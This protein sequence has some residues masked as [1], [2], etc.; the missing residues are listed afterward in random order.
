MWSIFYVFY[1]CYN[2]FYVSWKKNKFCNENEYEILYPSGSVLAHIYDTPKM[3][4]F[5]SIDSFPKLCPIV[6]PIR[7]SNYNL[8]HFLFNLLPPLVP[9][10]YSCKDF[11][12]VSQIKNENLS[13]KF[14]VFYNVT[15][16]FTNIPLLETIDIAIIIIFNHNHNLNITKKELKKLF[17]FANSQTH[18]LWIDGVAMGSPMAPVLANNFMGFYKSKW[19]NEYYIILINLNFILRYVDE[20]PGAFDKEQ[21]S[22][23]FQ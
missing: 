17:L 21:D 3:H 6:S 1:V 15:S 12:F 4:K 11:Y 22:V 19:L 23:N 20:I 5:S 16:L 2:I 7:T 10:D 18:F 13:R 9:S 14:L 8:A